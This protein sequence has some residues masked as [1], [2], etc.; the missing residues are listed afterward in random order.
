MFTSLTCINT[1]YFV[2]KE[3]FERKNR[4]IHS[5]L[6]RSKTPPNPPKT[7]FLQANLAVRV[8]PKDLP[9]SET[10]SHVKICSGSGGRE[11]IDN[12]EIVESVECH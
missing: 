9:M 8:Y 3:C 2:Y 12:C 4:V 10:P 1:N 7:V 6:F 5:P 11:N